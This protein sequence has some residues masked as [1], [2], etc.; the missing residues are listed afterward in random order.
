MEV[1]CFA[2][3]VYELSSSGTV[4]CNE[5]QKRIHALIIGQKEIIL[6]ESLLKKGR[7]CVVK[8]RGELAAV[9]EENQPFHT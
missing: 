5:G 9:E 7:K 6:S 8:L 1:D 3:R 4:L 2:Y